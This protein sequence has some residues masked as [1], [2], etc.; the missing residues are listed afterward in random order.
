MAECDGRSQSGDSQIGRHLGGVPA[1][2][3]FCHAQPLFLASAEPGR[4]EGEQKECQQGWQRGV[5]PGGQA[6]CRRG[7]RN[8]SDDPTGHRSE[9]RGRAGQKYQQRQAQADAQRGLCSA[10]Q[11]AVAWRR[12]AIAH[13]G[14]TAAS[15]SHDCHR[16]C[17]S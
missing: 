2:L 13:Q 17:C 11:T 10:I 14:T 4:S 5:I 3:V 1:T 15:T 6:L 9:R 16:I 12:A 7:V 8:R